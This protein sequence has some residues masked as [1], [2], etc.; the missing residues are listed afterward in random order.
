MDTNTGMCI[1][2]LFRNAHADKVKDQ[3]NESIVPTIVPGWAL[4]WSNT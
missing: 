3:M 2:V 1:M 4:W